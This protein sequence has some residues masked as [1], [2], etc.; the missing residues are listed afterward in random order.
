MRPGSPPSA[1]L[2]SRCGF[3]FEYANQ[4]ATQSDG[5]KDTGNTRQQY[6]YGGFVNGRP[7]ARS[8]PGLMLGLGAHM[9]FNRD[10][11]FD[12]TVN[13]DDDADHLQMFGAVQYLLFDQLYIKGVVAYALA[14][15]NPTPLSSPSVYKSEVVNGRLRLEY[16]F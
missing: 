10:K 7:L 13:R 3:N 9:T 8:V 15:T 4:S 2:R 11:N 14:H 16:F 6:T 5:T 1:L 12:P